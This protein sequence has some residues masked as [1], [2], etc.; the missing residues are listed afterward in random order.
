[1]KVVR[2]SWG[3]SWGLAGYVI[4]SLPIRPQICSFKLKKNFFFSKHFFRFCICEAQISATLK[5]MRWPR[6]R[7]Q[8][9]LLSLQERRTTSTGRA[10]P[11]VKWWCQHVLTGAMMER[12]WD[13]WQVQTIALVFAQLLPI[14]ITLPGGETG[15]TWRCP[16]SPITP[17]WVPLFQLNFQSVNAVT[18]SIVNQLGRGQPTVN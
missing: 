16:A 13:R 1:M 10:H 11:T 17:R 8:V 18:S 9:T 4:L 3:T 5:W 15:V 14:A 6:R 7:A 2:N 12:C